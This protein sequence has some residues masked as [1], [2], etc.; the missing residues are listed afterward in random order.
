MTKLEMVIQTLDIFQKTYPEDAFI[1]VTDNEKVVGGISGQHITLQFP[2][3]TPMEALQGTVIEKALRAGGRVQEERPANQ[4]VATATPIYEGGKM[5][6]AVVAVV[7]NKK[8]EALRS[9][10]SELAAMVEEM[11]ATTDEVTQVSQ[12]V[13]NRVTDTAEMSKIMSNDVEDIHSVASFVQQ[14]ASQSQL[15]GLNAAIEASRAGEHGL[16]FAVVADEMRKMAEQSKR[17]ANDIHEKLERIRS[18]IH[19]LNAAIHEILANTEEHLASMQELKET[20]EHIAR[21]ADDLAN[22]SKLQ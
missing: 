20:Y 17:S 1:F 12:N 18:F 10:A 19:E 14:V 3:G 15:L 5:V 9:S 8:Y 7:S 11:S 4:V 6:G 13:S 22:F 2:V 16:G 21:T